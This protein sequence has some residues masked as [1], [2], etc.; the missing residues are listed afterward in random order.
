MSHTTLKNPI[1]FHWTYEQFIQLRNPEPYDFLM[2]GT[3]YELDA[4]DKSTVFLLIF[5]GWDEKS[6]PTRPTI[7]STTILKN[8]GKSYQA[9]GKR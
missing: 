7:S 9:P 4:P 6:G 1:Q 5:A 8:P 2:I 3:S